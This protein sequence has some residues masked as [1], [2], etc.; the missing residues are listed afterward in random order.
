MLVLHGDHAD[1]HGST[2]ILF[3]FMQRNWTIQ[4]LAE[5]KSAF[6]GELCILLERVSNFRQCVIL[7]G[8]PKA[9]QGRPLF[10]LE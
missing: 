8:R 2:L 4:M 5:T 1:P 7:N 10:F 9:A 6:I 3:A